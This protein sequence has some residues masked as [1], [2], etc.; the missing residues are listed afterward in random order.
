[1][2]YE[3]IEIKGL[4]K[5]NYNL[6]QTEEIIE[7][8]NSN[9]CDINLSIGLKKYFI[10][11]FNDIKSIYCEKEIQKTNLKKLIN[12]KKLNNLK[13]IN[14]TIGYIKELYKDIYL[15]DD[16]K[17]KKADMFLWTYGKILLKYWIDNGFMEY[18]GVSF[19][20]K[21]VK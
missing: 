13:Y 4:N 21:S 14:I 7:N 18:G 20:P 1:M 6:E 11:S 9:I 12:S 2:N 5:I 19:D 3:K 16:Y 8:D 15:S 17:Y 10:K